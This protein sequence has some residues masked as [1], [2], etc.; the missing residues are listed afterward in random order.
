MKKLIT[1]IIT[2]VISITITSCSDDDN[3]RRGGKRRFRDCPFR[4]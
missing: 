3:D 4:D 1:V 2:I